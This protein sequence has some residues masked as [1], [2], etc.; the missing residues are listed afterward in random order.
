LNPKNPLGA[1]VMVLPVEAR[2]ELILALTASRA[3]NIEIESVMATAKIT[4]TPIERMAFRNAFL[5]PRR[6][7]FTGQPFVFE[8][9]HLVGA[10]KGWLQVS[11]SQP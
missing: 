5:T 8:S 7:E 10:V 9:R 11:L 6:R 1:T 4:T 2:T 3:I